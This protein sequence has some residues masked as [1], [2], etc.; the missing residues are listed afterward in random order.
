M[1]QMWWIQQGH[2][3]SKCGS[4][5]GTILESSTHRLRNLQSRNQPT[6][7]AEKDVKNNYASKLESEEDDAT[8]KWQAARK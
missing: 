7:Q 8:E 2:P 5:Y 6:E 1:I 4:F 3:N